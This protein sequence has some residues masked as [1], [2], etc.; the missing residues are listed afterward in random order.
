MALCTVSANTRYRF[1]PNRPL[2]NN[3]VMPAKI[4]M[5]IETVSH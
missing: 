4:Y 5:L 1:Q 2:R 3:I